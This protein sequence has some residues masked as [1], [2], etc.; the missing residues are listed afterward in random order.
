MDRKQ[1]LHLSL[2]NTSKL[3]MDELEGV[4]GWQTHL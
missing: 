1:E 3:F 2:R 4:E